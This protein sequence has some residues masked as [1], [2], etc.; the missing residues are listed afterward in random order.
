MKVWGFMGPSP[1]RSLSC[2]VILEIAAFGWRWRG[3]RR[4][5]MENMRLRIDGLKTLQSL[6][7]RIFSLTFA[8][9]GKA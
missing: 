6:S 4:L 5:E 8:L 9:I 7:F 2:R 3:L 1:K